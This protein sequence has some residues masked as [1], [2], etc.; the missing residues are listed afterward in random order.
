MNHTTQKTLNKRINTL[1]LQHTLLSPIPP[2]DISI[3]KITYPVRHEK[4]RHNYN[5]YLILIDRI[6]QHNW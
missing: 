5:N 2:T 4:M 1:R 6:D 3:T